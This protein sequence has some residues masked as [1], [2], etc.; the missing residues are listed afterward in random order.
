[1]L[2]IIFFSYVTLRCL[3]TSTE[4]VINVVPKGHIAYE[5]LYLKG[6]RMERERERTFWGEE[7]NKTPLLLTPLL[8]KGATGIGWGLQV[9]TLSVGTAVTDYISQGALEARKRRRSDMLQ[10]LTLL[11]LQ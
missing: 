11:H 10:V 9:L 7:Q 6:M 8:L 3:H 4:H 2:P 1:M 5:L